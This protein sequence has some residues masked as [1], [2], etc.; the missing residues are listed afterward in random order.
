MD[1]I[2]S[3][4]VPVYK[5]ESYLK[6]C[7][8]SLAAQSMT[9]IEFILVDDGSPDNCGVICDEY[10]ERDNRFH[11]IHQKNAGLSGARNTGIEV[12][13]GEYLMFVDSDD[14]VDSDYCRLPYESAVKYSADLVIFLYQESWNGELTD[15]ESSFSP[16]KKTNEESMEIIFSKVGNYAWNKLY[17][18]KL[19]SDLRFPVG[20]LFEDVATTYKIVN[21]ADTVFF[22]D[23]PLYY[24]FRNDGS[25]TKTVH[26]KYIL[27]YY[28]IRKMVSDDLIS[29]GYQDIARKL[30]YQAAYKYLVIKGRNGEYSDE[31]LSIC[32]DSSNW[33]E[34]VSTKQRM[35]QLC[36]KHFPVLFDLINS[37]LGR[38]I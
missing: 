3:V 11:V 9:D 2:I 30:R 22:L 27:D 15:V 25:I 38:H 12:A 4:I 13:R 35:M 6:R 32:R 33:P 31:C 20:R 19:F 7:L 37:A 1:P 21:T 23:V 18:R 10:A 26:E 29:W 14:W 17:H 34:T 8:D 28:E 16:G 24:Y 36:L 5:V